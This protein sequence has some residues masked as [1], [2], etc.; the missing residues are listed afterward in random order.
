[1]SSRIAL[2]RRGSCRPAPGAAMSEL[3]G[4]LRPI[5]QATANEIAARVI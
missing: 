3:V 4:Q 2:L 1:M 5:L